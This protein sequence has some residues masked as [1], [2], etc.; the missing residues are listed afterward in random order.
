LLA[1]RA[2]VSVDEAARDVGGQGS[3]IGQP[4]PLGDAWD[5]PVIAF[6]PPCDSA[7]L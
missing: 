6:D 3:R 5:G 1:G 2:P 7:S 4:V